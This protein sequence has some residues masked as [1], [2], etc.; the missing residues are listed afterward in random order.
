[1]LRSH[2]RYPYSPITAR[3]PGR[4][5]G[6]KGLAV[7]IALNLEQYAWGEGLVEHAGAARRCSR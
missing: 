7:Y 5:P 1:M 6:G 3:A 2:G 4:W